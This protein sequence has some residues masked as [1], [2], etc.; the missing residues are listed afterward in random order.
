M[1]TDI[2]T[3]DNLQKSAAMIKEGLE[4]DA[5]ELGGQIKEKLNDGQEYAKNSLHSLED[6]AK[7]N[8]LLCMGISFLVGMVVSKL[9][10]SSK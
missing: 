7:S 6:Q 4:Q 3:R 9:L 2:K 10:G 5:Y 8:P 1:A